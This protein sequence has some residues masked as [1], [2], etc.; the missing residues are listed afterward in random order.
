MREEEWPFTSVQED[1]SYMN[2]LSTRDLF[3]REN[4]HLLMNI[5]FL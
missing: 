4:A 1:G 3:L 5:A 2:Q